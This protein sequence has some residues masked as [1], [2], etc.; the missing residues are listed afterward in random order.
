MNVTGVCESESPHWRCTLSCVVI[1]RDVSSVLACWT[2]VCHAAS[3]S[4][5]LGP[6]V[7][8]LQ[9]TVC[10]NCLQLLTLCI[11]AS[12]ERETPSRTAS[13]NHLSHNLVESRRDSATSWSPEVAEEHLVQNK[14]LVLLMGFQ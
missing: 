12:A 7:S 4:V 11:R 10:M 1:Q 2:P 13:T 14:G 8:G 6:A 9:N 3:E 5:D